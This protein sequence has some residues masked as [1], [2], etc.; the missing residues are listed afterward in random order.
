MAVVSPD[1]AGHGVYRALR[2]ALA[3]HAY[4]RGYRFVVGDLS[5]TVTQRLFTDRLHHKN[6]AELVLA[7][8]VFDGKR[9]FAAIHTPSKSFWQKAAQRLLADR[10]WTRAVESGTTAPHRFRSSTG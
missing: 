6:C 5:S 1:F 7:D 8:C 3:I 9:R 2:I 4:D 10:Y